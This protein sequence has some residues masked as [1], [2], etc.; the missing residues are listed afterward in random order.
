MHV[1][2]SLIEHL[3]K[4]DK[5]TNQQIKTKQNKQAN[6]KYRAAPKYMTAL[7]ITIKKSHIM[8]ETKPPSNT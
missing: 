4:A 3:G 8:G 7:Y 6:P 5:Q 2:N 1:V